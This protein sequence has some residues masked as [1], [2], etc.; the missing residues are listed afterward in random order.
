VLVKISN[1]GSS[2]GTPTR[3][4]AKGNSRPGTEVPFPGE[5][6]SRIV[7]SGVAMIMAADMLYILTDEDPGE[8][9]RVVP[10]M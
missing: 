9:L 7:I 2:G 8:L 4:R 3:R 1:Q 10:R 6:K 5:R